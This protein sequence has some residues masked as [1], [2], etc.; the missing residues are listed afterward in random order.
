MLRGDGSV[1]PVSSHIQYINPDATPHPV[2]GSA[3]QLMAIS[4]GGYVPYA[5]VWVQN[6]RRSGHGAIACLA[7][8]LRYELGM[9]SWRLQ[10]CTTNGD[11]TVYVLPHTQSLYSVDNDINDVNYC[12]AQRRQLALSFM[13]GTSVSQASSIMTWVTDSGAKMYLPPYEI[14]R[15]TK[16][17]LIPQKLLDTWFQ[18]CSPWYVLYRLVA[19]RW[20]E[21]DNK[22]NSSELVRNKYYQLLNT[23]INRVDGRLSWVL[24][25]AMTR[26]DAIINYNY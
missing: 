2:L 7:D 6:Q 19:D 15:N 22:P 8:Q 26:L 4:P 16:H 14:M 17:V 20:P 1:I 3:A 11:N 18:N 13:L 24:A 25:N 23:I 10:W 5:N 9:D 12:T 21:L